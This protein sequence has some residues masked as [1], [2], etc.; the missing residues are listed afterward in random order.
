MQN[1]IKTIQNSISDTDR[2]IHIA[3]ERIDNYRSL[4]QPSHTWTFSI[5]LETALKMIFKSM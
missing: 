2:E 5:S 4:T 3:Y 1:D